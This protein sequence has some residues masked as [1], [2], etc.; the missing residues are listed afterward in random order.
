ME[1]SYAERHADQMMT[2]LI[3]NCVNCAEELI[4]IRETQGAETAE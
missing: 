2:R 3:R 4:L 1:E